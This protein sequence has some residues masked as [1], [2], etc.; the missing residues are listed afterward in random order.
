MLQKPMT[1]EEYVENNG[2]KCP[3]CRQDLIT[4]NVMG[5]YIQVFSVSHDILTCNSCGKSWM[6]ETELVGYYNM[7][8]EDPAD[9]TY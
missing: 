1:P 6:E 7:N 8:E 5:E 2:E 3:F 9:G 4:E